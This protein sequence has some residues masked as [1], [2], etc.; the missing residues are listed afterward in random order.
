MEEKGKKNAFSRLTGSQTHWFLTSRQAAD[1]S[2]QA[3][4]K[5]E[6]PKS[7]TNPNATT[8][9]QKRLNNLDS[10]ILEDKTPIKIEGENLKIE[11]RI[12]EKEKEIKTLAK[13]IKS[14][15]SIDNQPELL[16]LRARKQRIEKELRTLYKEYTSKDSMT[17][18]SKD[19]KGHLVVSN[20]R[21]M[22]VINAIKRFIQRY[23]L[24]KVSRRFRSL[25]MLSDS[26]D[27][28]NSISRNVDELL[29]MKT[30]YG[31]TA[32][33][34]EKLTEYLSKANK[35]RSQ[36]NKSIKR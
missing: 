17:T 34:Y 18:V 4:K 10:E 6:V 26:L 13:Q 1:I 32:D 7:V 20:P 14:A 15:E 23:I 28:L 3:T 27:N 31:E 25:V 19:N 21:K 35:I 30:P 8:P 33:N 36:I 24:A 22:P 9:H 16:T 2:A 11:Y 29:K 12:S 5:E